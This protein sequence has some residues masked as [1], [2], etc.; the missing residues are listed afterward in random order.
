VIFAAT[1]P[2]AIVSA[3][4]TAKP[5]ADQKNEQNSNQM[6]MMGVKMGG[7]QG[8]QDDTDNAKHQ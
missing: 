3:E 4:D 6:G 1:L 2:F 8:N 5:D 7:D